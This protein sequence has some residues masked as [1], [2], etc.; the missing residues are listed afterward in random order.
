MG[1][2]VWFSSVAP[3]KPDRH[4]GFSISAMRVWCNRGV[5]L[6]AYPLTIRTAL[7][8]R[9]RGGSKTCGGAHGAEQLVLLSRDAFV[10]GGYPVAR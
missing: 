1:Q 5:F 8:G 7:P 4:M 2:Y 9:D 6:T 3:A 10:A